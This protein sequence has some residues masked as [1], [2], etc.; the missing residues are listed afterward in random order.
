MTQV[1]VQPT[2]DADVAARL[3]FAAGALGAA[4]HEV[5]DPGLV[6]L[7][8]RFARG[9]ISIEEAGRLGDQLAAGR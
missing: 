3:D 5:T 4:G 6:S 8:Q 2:S 1:P 7:I 9:E